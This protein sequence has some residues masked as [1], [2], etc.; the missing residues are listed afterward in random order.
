MLDAMKSAAATRKT[1]REEQVQME[2]V[3]VPGGGVGK[4]STEFNRVMWR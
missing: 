1:G 3:E 2:D 4:S